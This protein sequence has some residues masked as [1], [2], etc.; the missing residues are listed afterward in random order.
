MQEIGRRRSC[1]FRDSS[2]AQ[3]QRIFFVVRAWRWTAVTVLKTLARRAPTES[4]SQLKTQQCKEFATWCFLL[5]CSVPLQVSVP[6]LRL[7]MDS[8]HPPIRPSMSTTLVT[9][10]SLALI[11]WI[12]PR[13]ISSLMTHRTKPPPVNSTSES[14]SWIGDEGLRLC[15]IS[16]LRQLTPPPFFVFC[17]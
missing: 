11:A 6:V 15:T 1:G 16:T 5:T 12:S 2:F 14:S 8:S 10:S 3:R 7:A 4:L 13:S 9:Q 17:L